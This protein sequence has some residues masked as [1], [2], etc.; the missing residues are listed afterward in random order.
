MDLFMGSRGLGQGGQADWG[1]TSSRTEP[2]REVRVGQGEQ[3]YWAK[4]SR[5][6]VAGGKH[7]DWSKGR[8]GIRP[9]GAGGLG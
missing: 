9:G 8:R 4:G 2:G 5:G 7:E 6:A 3:E 1:M